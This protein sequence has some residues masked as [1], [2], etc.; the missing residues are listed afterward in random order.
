MHETF[1]APS[2]KGILDADKHIGGVDVATA[3]AVLI[4][5]EQPDLILREPSGEMP[6][7]P[8]DALTI[9]TTLPVTDTTPR[10]VRRLMN[11]M[12]TLNEFS[13]ARLET[14]ELLL[15]EAITNAITAMNRAMQQDGRIGFQASLMNDEVDGERVLF[16]VADSIEFS[17]WTISQAGVGEE[18]GRGLFLIGSLC[19]RWGV[20]PHPAGKVVWVEV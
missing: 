7:I 10:K 15:S 16:A 5:E 11:G 19:R 12:L 4:G 18:S 9:S 20:C 3:P 6:V 2:T 8:I 13:S 17:Q 1:S 14:V